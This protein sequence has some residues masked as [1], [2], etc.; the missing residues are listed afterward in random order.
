MPFQFAVSLAACLS[1]LIASGCYRNS[2][3]I[4]GV[5]GTVSINGEPLTQG[6]V[7]FMTED[8]FGSSTRVNPDGTYL[9][10]SHLGKGIPHGVYMV[11]VSPSEEMLEGPDSPQKRELLSKYPEKYQQFET[12]PLRCEVREESVQFEI[13][14]EGSK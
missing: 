1:L 2:T 13:Q 8:G 6:V 3:P 4:T 14:L 10:R 9:M 7:G 11:T 12:T 5:T